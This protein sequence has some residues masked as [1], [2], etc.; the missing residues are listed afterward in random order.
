MLHFAKMSKFLKQDQYR[1]KHMLQFVNMVNVF[2]I[3]I[4]IWV[5]WVTEI[6]GNDNKLQKILSSK[7]RSV[8]KTE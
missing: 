3:R 7:A 4:R 2:K 5:I 1:V 8:A 6:A